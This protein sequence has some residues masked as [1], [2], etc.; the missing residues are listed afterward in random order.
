M[1]KGVDEGWLFCGNTSGGGDN[2]RIKHIIQ[3]FVSI[4]FKTHS[5]KEVLSSEFSR[6]IVLI[7]GDKSSE[8]RRWGSTCAKC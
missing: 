6:R 8:M 7:S 4:N 1:C 5:L 2:M 3:T